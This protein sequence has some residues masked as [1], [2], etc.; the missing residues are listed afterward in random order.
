M[1]ELFLVRLR[2]CFKC[3]LSEKSFRLGG[4][5]QL[6]SAHFIGLISTSQF[7]S[8][9]SHFGG[10]NPFVFGVFKVL[11]LSLL[12]VSG[13]QEALT[14]QTLLLLLLYD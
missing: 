4:I 13:C 3:L 9:L 6:E 8:A 5:F 12:C 11:F 14:P 7:F 2:E 1:G 10:R